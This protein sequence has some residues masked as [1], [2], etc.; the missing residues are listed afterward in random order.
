MTDSVESNVIKMLVEK[1]Q[2]LVNS[3]ETQKTFIDKLID[4]CQKQQ[5]LIDKLYNNNVNTTSQITTV[6]VEKK[7]D[8]EKALENVRSAT[9]YYDSTFQKSY[10]VIWLKNA[11]QTLVDHL[12]LTL[13]EENG[14]WAY[15]Q[16]D[17]YFKKYSDWSINVSYERFMTQIYPHLKKWRLT[18]DRLVIHHLISP[19]ITYIKWNGSTSNVIGFND[20]ISESLFS[21]FQQAYDGIRVSQNNKAL[22][23][24]NNSFTKFAQHL[25]IT[26][27]KLLFQ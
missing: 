14:A 8:M 22:E 17:Q 6:E 12:K 1:N 16:I 13:N 23:F 11:D 27:D 20:A 10:V 24:S 5:A 25:N 26:Y 7:F 18:C 2:V 21:I 9:V 4:T 3:L 19:H 15:T